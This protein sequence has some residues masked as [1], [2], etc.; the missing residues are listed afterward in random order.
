MKAIGS[1]AGAVRNILADLV[2]RETQA[3]KD[4]T[5]TFVKSV[6]EYMGQSTE[7]KDSPDRSA[8]FAV[9]STAK[10]PAVLIELAY[11]SNKE[12]AEL[13]KS[14]QWRGKVADS[15]V[16]AIDNYFSHQVARLPMYGALPET[17]NSRPEGRP[18]RRGRHA[19]HTLTA[20]AQSVLT[21][22]LQRFDTPQQPKMH[23]IGCMR[24]GS[25]RLR[26]V[27]SRT[28]WTPDDGVSAL[29][30]P[31]SLRPF[32]PPRS[33]PP[34]TRSTRVPSFGSVQENDAEE[35]GGRG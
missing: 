15:I 23:H 28:N 34:Q 3:T 26:S 14:D 11:V 33:G 24:R 17:E 27:L 12:D 20:M 29:A 32:T 1:D 30:T 31:S 21:W 8:A 22:R 6:I 9:L 16:T 2:Q 7:L 19:S 25:T 18:L 13:L 5:G 4:R 35:N 10:V